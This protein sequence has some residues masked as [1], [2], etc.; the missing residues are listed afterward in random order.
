MLGRFSQRIFMGHAQRQLLKSGVPIFAYHKI[1]LPPAATRDSFLYVSPGEFEAQL[2]ELERAGFSSAALDELVPRA[3]VAENASCLAEKAVITFDDG[4]RSVLENGLESLSRH[5]F[6]A[7]QF[8]VAGMLGKKN[9]WDVAKGDVAEDLMD[10]IQIREWIAAGHEIGSHSNTH[11]NLRHLS[12]AEAREEISGSKK[13][14]EDRFGIEVRH[15]CYPYGSWN[16]AVRDLAAEAGYRSAC[17]L[18][19]GVNEPMTPAYE[20]R[21]IIPLSNGEM[22]RKI[23]HRLARKLGAW[24][25]AN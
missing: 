25:G 19:F 22:A 6:H 14:L 11:R 18:V 1:A 10:E 13:S 9:A 21:R 24:L 16:E 12:A 4:F 3:K 7:I 23:R 5:K 17:S 8:L 15:F 2:A 20:L